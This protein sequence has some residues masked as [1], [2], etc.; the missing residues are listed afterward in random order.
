[1]FSEEGYVYTGCPI[2]LYDGDEFSLYVDVEQVFGLGHSSLIFDLGMQLEFSERG[3][4]QLTEEFGLVDFYVNSFK[5]QDE[6]IFIRTL[7]GYHSKENKDFAIKKASKL[8][9]IG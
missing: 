7:K 4:S 5:L 9:G 8:L 6:G 1:M 2:P 3:S